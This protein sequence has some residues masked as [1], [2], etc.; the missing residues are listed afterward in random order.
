MGD[1]ETKVRE[2][3]G[4]KAQRIL[5]PCGGYSGIS[6]HS[7]H[8]ESKIQWKAHASMVS[9]SRYKAGRRVFQ[10]S[11]SK[12]FGAKGERVGTSVVGKT[13]GRKKVTADENEYSASCCREA[14][15]ALGTQARE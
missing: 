4:G 13:K 1:G 5:M 15:T 10:S 6:P 8:V 3:L 7:S 14:G 2:V 12:D 9:A 11:S